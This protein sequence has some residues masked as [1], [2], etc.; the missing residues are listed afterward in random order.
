MKNEKR[1]RVLSVAFRGS[2]ERLERLKEILNR[3]LEEA[4]PNPRLEVQDIFSQ[5]GGWVQDNSPG[6]SPFDQAGGWF[7]SIDDQVTK[8]SRPDE[9]L[10]QVTKTVYTA[11]SKA[12][13]IG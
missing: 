1:D 5:S 12:E 9:A 8:V 7:L 2:A 11:L 10:T 6:Q 4:A 3:L 13:Q